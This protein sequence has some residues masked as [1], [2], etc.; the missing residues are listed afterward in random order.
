M[1]NPRELG[2]D[3]LVNAVAAHAAVGGPCVV[4]DFGTA[5][6][7]DCVSAGG[8]YLGGILVPGRRDLAR[9][10]DHAGR[11]DPQD[12]PRPPAHA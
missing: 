11:R 9:G 12:R 10:A 5:I 1:D 4:V 8:E 3:R 6:T 2:P 7:Y